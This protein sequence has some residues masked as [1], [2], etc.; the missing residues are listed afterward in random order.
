M[1]KVL[2][3]LILMW[4]F[5]PA[6]A[7]TPLNTAVD[8]TVTTVDNQSFNLFTQ[9]NNNKFVLIDFFFVN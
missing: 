7:Q 1:K 9:L 8:F 5:V 2:T 6:K 4:L 3:I